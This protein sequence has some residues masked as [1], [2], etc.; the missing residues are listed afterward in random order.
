[1]SQPE[2][3]SFPEWSHKIL[4]EKMNDPVEDVISKV[5]VSKATVFDAATPE[6]ASTME[7]TPYV[8]MTPMSPKPKTFTAKENQKKPQAVLVS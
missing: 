4:L 2:F 3:A 8:P 6:I 5:V 1:M 7:P